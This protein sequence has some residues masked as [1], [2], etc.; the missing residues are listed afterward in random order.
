MMTPGDCPVVMRGVMTPA[1]WPAMAWG[2]ED[3][4]AAV[5]GDKVR[6]EYLVEK[7]LYFSLHNH[8]YRCHILILGQGEGEEGAEESGPG[9]P[10]V[11]ARHQD[12]GGQHR[13]VLRPGES[14]GGHRDRGVEL[15]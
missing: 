1:D 9:H 10:A 2:P 5:A 14:E 15:L 7:R 11:G 6:G 13:R 8:S 3:W 4:V 12:S